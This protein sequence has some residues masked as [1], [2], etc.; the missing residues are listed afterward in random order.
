MSNGRRPAVQVRQDEGVGPVGTTAPDIAGN[1][2]TGL[3]AV[4]A[5]L[6]PAN[7]KA[8]QVLPDLSSRYAYVTLPWYP[9][10]AYDDVCIAAERLGRTNDDRMLTA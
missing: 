1:A 9:G 6:D 2:A 10:P 7:A 5:D 4:I 3:K 8:R